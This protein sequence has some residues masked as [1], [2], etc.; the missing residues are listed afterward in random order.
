MKGSRI[1][2]DLWIP[3]VVFGAWFVLNVWVL[4]K[5]GVAT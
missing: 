1:M 5:F 2:N 3:V 4:P